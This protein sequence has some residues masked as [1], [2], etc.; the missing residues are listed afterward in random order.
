MK[1]TLGGFTIIEVMMVLAISGVLLL[2]ASVTLNGR[3]QSTEFSQAALDL[4]SQLQ[5]IA[6]SVSSQAIPGIKQFTCAPVLISGVMRPTLTSGSATNQDCIYLGQVVQTAAGSTSLYSYP[7]FGLRTVYNGST[8]TG[9]APNS[10]AEANAAPA[11]NSSDAIIS[12]LKTTY[13]MMNG[14]SVVSAKLGGTESDIL[15]FYSSLQNNNTSGNEIDVAAMPVTGNA[16]A[17]DAQVKG[18]I[19]YFSG[20]P[21]SGTPANNSS[22]NLCVSAG[23]RQAQLSVK[24]IATGIVTNLNMNGC[25]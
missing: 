23:G 2:S 12:S 16:A 22:W 11:I 14:L 20:C 17:P 4:Q 15:T 13:T 6:N 19:E 8:D 9:N 24:A 10:P 18:C 1:V 5:S 7:V 21:A 3:R 25:T